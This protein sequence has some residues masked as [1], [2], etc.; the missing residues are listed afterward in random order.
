MKVR[1]KKYFILNGEVYPTGRIVGEGDPALGSGL[2][3]CLELFEEEAPAPPTPEPV[4]ADPLKGILNKAAL[5][6]S[7]RE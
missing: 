4:K 7:R 1:V 3:H 5:T 2:D 6:P